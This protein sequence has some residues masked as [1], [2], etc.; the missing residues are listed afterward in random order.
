[1]QK[2]SIGNPLK[3]FQLT[4]DVKSKSD[5]EYCKQLG[6]YIWGQVTDANTGY[7]FLR[8]TRI[9]S[10]RLMRAGRMDMTRFMDLLGMDG[11][12]NYVNINWESIQICGTIINKLIGRWMQRDEKIEATAIDPKS[13]REKQDA[14][15][16]AEFQMEYK[17]QLDAL[18]Q[19]S[20]IPMTRPDQ[21]VP[22][23][24]DELELWT[25]DMNRLPEEITFELG[26]NNVFDKNGWQD[27]LKRMLLDDLATTGYCGTE[28]YAGRDGVI[29]VEK[30]EP[31]NMFYSYSIYSDFR[32]TS[33]RGRVK[34][35]KIRDI[36]YKYP[37][38]DEKELFDLAQKSKQF[39][40]V[41]K[42]RWNGDWSY[43]YNRPYDDWNVDVICFELKT[44]DVDTY[45]IKTTKN[46]STIIDK[47]PKKIQE[48]TEGV[49]KPK[50]NIYRGVYTCGYTGTGYVLEWGLKKNMI[51]PQDPKEMGDA[52]FSYSFYMYTPFEMR[53]KAIPERIKEP[54]EQMILSR[55]K[56]QQLVA[57]MR[58]AG[59][60]TDID[61]LQALDLGLG[62]SVT[63]IQ[64]QAIYDQTGNYYYRSKDEEGNPIPHPFTEL[65][66][67]GSVQQLQE[68]VNLYNFHLGVIKDEIGEDPNLIDKAIQPR[69]TSGNVEA[70]QMQSQFATDYIYDAYLA[71]MED[72]AGKVCCLLSDSIQYG[73]KEYRDL[74]GEEQIKDRYFSMKIKMKSSDAEVAMIDAMINNAMTA[75]PTLLLYCD[76][77]KIKRI[78]KENVKLAELYFYQCQKRAM[79]GEMEKSAQ[80]QE[81]NGQIQ[82]QSAQA[83]S[84]ADAQLKQMESQMEIAKQTAV[85]IGQQK[86]TLL[87]GIMDMYKTG[88][89]LPAGIAAFEQ[90]ILESLIVPLIVQNDQ[91]KQNVQAMQEEE[92]QEQQQ[93]PQQEMMEE[94][95]EQGQ[96]QNEPQMM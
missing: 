15:D 76:P 56:I 42:L 79:K 63:P 39:N 7:Y 72:T 93:P 16:E 81:Q 17:P 47:N 92:M 64:M 74:M 49:A 35:M 87:S 1:M 46:N 57:K 22:Q 60:A 83:K 67:A 53:N 38:M 89:P 21:F 84:R 85:N 55:L 10:N 13:I 96:M 66:N 61:A 51:R 80:L 88:V 28:T 82:I 8:N 14:V 43:A 62:S 58:P 40:A 59:M 44:T 36:R 3:E 91:M 18:Q 26:C 90:Q 6:N 11:K 5:K 37:D 24:R 71:V 94:Q 70:A 30:V 2:E 23:D 31:E 75:N 45:Q 77:F 27:T 68:L 34:S 12:T 25:R 20:G 95:Q 52:E 69:V 9:R 65:A 4:G 50:I 19:A 29:I 73:G 78:A 48:G 41:D 32:D 86:T 33:Y 54:V